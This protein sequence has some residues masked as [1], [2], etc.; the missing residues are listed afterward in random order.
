MLL[1]LID[2]FSKWTELVPLRSA[3]S[4]SL[5]KA[6]KERIIARYGVPKIV[7]TDNGEQFA[8]K[9]FK[10]FLAE[11]GAKQQ[12]TAPYIPQ[13]N[14][15]ERANRT[16]PYQVMGCAS[17]VICKIRHINTKKDRT[18]HVSEL[19][20]QQTENTSERL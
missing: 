20:Q 15:T 9:L 1:V 11:M 16:D 8:R 19:K 2:R 3:T 14:P 13:E 17:P 5:K 18:I 10:S 6:F 12:F 7:I 4:E